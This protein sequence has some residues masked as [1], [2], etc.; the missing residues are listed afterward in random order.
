LS[1]R[2]R[3]AFICQ[4]FHRVEVNAVCGDPIQFKMA[5]IQLGIFRKLGQSYGSPRKIAK[6]K[7][8]VAAIDNAV[9]GGFRAMW[10]PHSAGQPVFSGIRYATLSKKILLEELRKETE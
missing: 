5:K 3:H 1:E 9:C 2:W 6:G 4:K 10:Y 8:Q 7:T